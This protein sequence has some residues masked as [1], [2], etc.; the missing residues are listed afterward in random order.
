MINYIIAAVF[1]GIFYFAFRKTARDIKSN[2]CSCGSSCSD[3]SK[4]PHSK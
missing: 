1:L 4:C 3:P 2:K